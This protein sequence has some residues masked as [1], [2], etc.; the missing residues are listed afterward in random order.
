MPRGYLNEV[1]R[2]LFFPRLDAY[3]ASLRGPALG[4][5]TNFEF[6][7]YNSR[8]DSD[9]ANRLIENSKAKYLLGYSKDLGSDFSMG[10][11]YLYEQTLDYGNYKKAL[12]GADF[13]WDKHRHLLTLRL[14]QLFKSQT[15]RLNLFTFVSPSDRDIYIRPSIA[16]DVNDNCQLTLG[17]NL[18]WGEDNHTEFGQMEKNNNIYLRVRYSF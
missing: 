8:Q 14:T 1:N 9:G 10:A 2:E 5:I 12:L 15:V 17:A 18:I 11:Q 16:Y 13:R 6:G 3:G 4:G 7:Y